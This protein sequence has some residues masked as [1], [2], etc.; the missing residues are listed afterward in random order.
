MQHR[1]FS[2]SHYDDGE[3]CQRQRRVPEGEG[4][5]EGGWEG[6]ERKIGK[7]RRKKAEDKREERKKQALDACW[8]SVEGE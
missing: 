6:S 1:V 3:N 8:V 4:D 5:G 2:S 7:G